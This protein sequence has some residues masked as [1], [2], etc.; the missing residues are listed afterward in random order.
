[1][2]GN[3]M[4]QSVRDAQIAIVGPNL[5][6]QLMMASSF[7]S[8]A[9]GNQAHRLVQPTIN[10]TAEYIRLFY[11]FYCI[12]LLISMSVPLSDGGNEIPLCIAFL[13]TQ[14]LNNMAISLQ[15]SFASDVFSTVKY[16]SFF[17]AAATIGQFAGSLVALLPFVSLRFLPLL[18]SIS[19]EFS[20]YCMVRSASLSSE[21]P[22][23]AENKVDQLW[24]GDYYAQAIAVY[25]LFYASSLSLIYL[26]R[27]AAV[28]DEMDFESA[29]RTS[30]Q[31]NVVAAILTFAVQV[32]VARG[33]SFLS[34]IDVGIFVLPILTLA[35][36]VF[37]QFSSQYHLWGILAFELLRRIL[38]FAIVKPVREA[39]YNVM[40]RR[41]K[42]SV[43]SVVDT[44]MYKGGMG[45]GAA[46]YRWNLNVSALQLTLFYVTFSVL[47]ILC[48]VVILKQRNKLC[49]SN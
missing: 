34:R 6:S 13:C 42:Y 23:K 26:E 36:V 2:L 25:M 24:L 35:H 15:W 33:T 41:K 45:I 44:F 14:T 19:L 46:M 7:L 30:A 4:L 22:R 12:V 31:L 16:F 27:T 17:G 37:F 40:E 18:V 5:A 8:L 9:V 11:R 21:T 29:A 3:Y 1:M 48:S 10:S 39:L 38:A 43:K 20:S 32:Q 28:S 47:W 49:N